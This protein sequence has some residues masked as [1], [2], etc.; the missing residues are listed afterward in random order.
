MKTRHS[1]LPDSGRIPHR[2]IDNLLHTRLSEAYLDTRYINVTGDTM[3]GPLHIQT[4][5]A[6]APVLIL[7]TTDDD[8]TNNLI[9]IQNSG[10]NVL[11]GADERGILFSDGNTD[12]SNL[13]LGDDAGRMAMTGIHNVLLGQSVG[14]ALT[15]GSYNVGIGSLVL[16]NNTIGAAN[17]ALGYAALAANTTGDQNIAIGQSA[18][19][20]NTTGEFNVAIGSAA[21]DVNTTASFNIAIGF[22]ALLL[23]TTGHSNTAIG[24]KSLRSN[25]TGYGNWAAG[26]ET[27]LNNTTGHYNLALGYQALKANIGGLINTAIGAFTLLS[28]TAGDANVAVGYASLVFNVTGDNNVAIGQ[29]AGRNI[30][31]DGNVLIGYEA[32]GN[33]VGSNTLYIANSNITT[34]LIYGEFDGAGNIGLMTYVPTATAV[35]FTIR[36]A[37]DQSANLL[38]LQKSDGSIFLAS[39]DGLG[40]SVFSGNQQL[41]DIDLVW[42]SGTEANLLRVDAGLDQVRH[43]DWHTNYFVTDKLGDSWWVGGGGL[44]SGT[45]YGN[46]IA[47]AQAAAAQNTWYNISDADMISGNLHNVTHDGNGQLTALIAGMYWAAYSICFEDDIA[48]DHIE[49]GLEINGGGAAEANGQCHVENKFAN[50]EEHL[51]TGTVLDLAANDTVEVTIR[52]T[53]AGTPDITVHAV[54]LTLVHIGGT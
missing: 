18:L 32:G 50:E 4:P 20:K 3:T 9:E 48:N 45:C 46:H 13:I 2:D 22:N 31:G 15:T 43:G 39:G 36:G 51:G 8:L 16:Q 12:V 42:A 19:R 38:E 34:P 24:A 29:G 41:E 10:T 27:M 37:A 25:L 17:M 28:N 6:T 44:P 11:S 5:T 40:D 49:T 35:G 52:T 47:W 53:D 33:E 54:N 23:N 14:T 26:F 1:A 30:L 21:L 7:Q